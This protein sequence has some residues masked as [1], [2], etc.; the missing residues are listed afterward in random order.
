MRKRWIERLWDPTEY[1]KDY[2]KVWDLTFCLLIFILNFSK[3]ASE[4]F[5]SQVA[6]LTRELK[7]GTFP[8]WLFKTLNSNFFPT[9][10][11]T[12]ESSHNSLPTFLDQCWEFWLCFSAHFLGSIFIPIMTSLAAEFS[13]VFSATICHSFIKTG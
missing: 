12:L 1:H 13:F 6:N 4:K 5:A 3:W 2:S 11:D 8:P 10:I 7:T 9:V